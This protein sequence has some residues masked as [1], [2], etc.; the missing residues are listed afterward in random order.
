MTRDHD[1]LF[2]SAGAYLLGALPEL[3]H[4]AFER[5]VMGCPSCRDEVERLR[6]A[7]EALPRSVT[8]LSSPASLRR[9]LMGI[10]AEEAAP[11]REDRI[12][13]LRRRLTPVGRPRRRAALAL[14]GAAFLLAVGVAGGFGA[15][16]LI[17]KDD[18]RSVA[19]MV[20]ESELAEGSARLLVPGDEGERA[21]V[22]FSG[23]PP[24]P[25]RA[26]DDV[27]QLWISRGGEVVPSSVFSV[28]SDGSG[29]AALDEAL[30]GADAVW[31]TRERAGGARAPT[32]SPVMS[33]ELG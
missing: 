22:H 21:V 14:V 26:G 31:V 7:A 15:S 6:V 12:A 25:A 4:E 32:E 30:D 16:S 11:S 27:Y 1:Q 23:L 28:A 19:A 18:P 10:V 20:D 8:Q 3:E 33:F 13:R 2:D 29:T 17:G 5:H 24:L 9:P